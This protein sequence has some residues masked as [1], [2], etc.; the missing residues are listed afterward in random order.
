MNISCWNKSGHLYRFRFPRAIIFRRNIYHT[1]SQKSQITLPPS[2]EAKA[3][4]SQS[5]HTAIRDVTWNILNYGVP[6]SWQKC[7][8]SLFSWNRDK[9]AGCLYFPAAILPLPLLKLVTAQAGTAGPLISQYK[10]TLAKLPSSQKKVREIP[11][12]HPTIQSSLQNIPIMSSFSSTDK[13]TFW[14]W[15]RE[16]LAALGLSG[17]PR[18]QWA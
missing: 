4:W 1:H 15:R 7:R 3:S 14:S 12:P 8:M 5:C 6:K 16:V 10:S 9:S 2:S 13:I 11:E 18:D 17:M